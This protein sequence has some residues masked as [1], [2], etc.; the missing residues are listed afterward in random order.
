V[1]N[2][3]DLQILTFAMD[4]DPSV[5]EA[6]MRENKLTFPVIVAPELVERLF[7]NQGGLREQPTLLN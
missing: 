4:A 6:Y 1:K 7:T 3:P 2:S 5:V